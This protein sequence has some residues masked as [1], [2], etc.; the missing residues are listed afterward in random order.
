MLCYDM[1]CYAVM[2][3]G[4]LPACLRTND[5]EVGG[6]EAGFM[7]AL[8]A[9]TGMSAI[10]IAGVNIEWKIMEKAMESEE[11]IVVIQNIFSVMQFEKWL[12]GLVVLLGFVPVGSIVSSL[13][14]E[15]KKQGIVSLGCLI[16]LSII[17]LLVPSEQ[18]LV[19]LLPVGD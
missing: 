9:G 8:L 14:Q 15:R 11:A 5:T 10:C 13:P 2:M 16:S 4:I 7:S 1:I 3:L 19:Q 17:A 6:L 18:I 12:L